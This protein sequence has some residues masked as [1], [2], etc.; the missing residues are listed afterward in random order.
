MKFIKECM[1]SY[2]VFYRLGFNH[3]WDSAGSKDILKESISANPESRIMDLGC[4]DGYFLYIL[5]SNGLIGAG[6]GVDLSEEA[7]QRGNKLYPEINLSVQNLCFTSYPDDYFDGIIST[8]LQYVSSPMIAFLEASR[9]LKSSGWFRFM[10][11]SLEA[12]YGGEQKEEC[13]GLDNTYLPQ[14]KLKRSTWERLMEQSGLKLESPSIPGA[15]H[16]ECFFFGRKS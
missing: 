6:Y 13:F 4:G 16:P 5:K 9:L 12:Y 7:I 11:P 1:N 3:S 10:I 2:D 8:S 15:I 14:W